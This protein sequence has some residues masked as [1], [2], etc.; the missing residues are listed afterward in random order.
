MDAPGGPEFGLAVR[1]MV[2]VLDGCQRH[3]NR[4][5]RVGPSGQLAGPGH[6]Q[7]VDIPGPPV[8]SWNILPQTDPGFDSRP[9]P[10]SPLARIAAG[11]RR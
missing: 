7:V 3:W 10:V 9:E 1:S 11:S 6:T 8:P 2:S 4:R 5:S